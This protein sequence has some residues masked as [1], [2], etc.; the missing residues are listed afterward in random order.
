MPVPLRRILSAILLALV[1]T[2]T[3]LTM[4]ANPAAAAWDPQF[5]S[6]WHIR[7]FFAGGSPST[8]A[9]DARFSGGHGTPVQLWT[10]NGLEAEMW[11][12]EPAS[13][14]GA[15]YHPGYNRWLCLDFNGERGAGIPLVVNN[16]D[17]SDSQRWFRSA[18]GP[19]AVKLTTH[20]DNAYCVDVPSSQFNSG[21]GLWIWPCNGGNAQRFH[22]AGCFGSNCQGLDP[23][24]TFCS[25][26]SDVS[27]D[28]TVGDNRVTLHRS[29]RCSTVWARMTA[30]PDASISRHVT[31]QRL[32]GGVSQGTLS[33]PPV[34]QGNPVGWTP[35]YTI[36]SS[37]YY[38]RACWVYSGTGQ[39][40][41]GFSVSY[42]P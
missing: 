32:L 28:F 30:D 12:E 26:E 23:A 16:C 3:G 11:V 42:V 5:P 39:T 41:C 24:L 7:T 35:M 6:N 31:V 29:G 18:N 33:S 14:G 10:S 40:V 8:L 4:P 21:Q 19:N 15:Y 9:M 34:S 37:Q 38:Y 13:E 2:T 20:S 25:V 36:A 22:N 27:D 1:A 17:G